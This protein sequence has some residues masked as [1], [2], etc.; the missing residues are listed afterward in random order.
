MNHDDR[1]GRYKLLVF[2]W[3]GTLIDSIDG[4]VCSLQIA[5]R[6]IC[7]KD[8]SV[9]RAR[10]VIGL[11]LREA[12]EALHPELE[13][14]HVDRV[15]EAYRQHYLYRNPNRSKLFAGVREMLEQLR[16]A[17]FLLAIATGKSRIGLD[18]V[19]AEHELAT[20]FNASRCAGECRSKPHP[21]MLLEILDQLRTHAS[22]ALMIGDS[23]HDL[24]M[25]NNAG[26]DAVAVTHGVNTADELVR[27]NPV[28]CLDDITDLTAVISH[29]NHDRLQ[30]RAINPIIKEPNTS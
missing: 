10:S 12:I 1:S 22:Q 5:S 4:I 2:D 8:V 18:R 24:L 17:G 9:Q 6:T 15:A 26:V 11:G 29:N 14:V 25:A 23:G 7:N 27:Y 20:F 3:D 19:L 28:L 13:S 21:Q 30:P 16:D